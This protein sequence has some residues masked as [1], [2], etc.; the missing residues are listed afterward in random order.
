MQFVSVKTTV[1]HSVFF[2]PFSIFVF[3]SK[4]M[5]FIKIREEFFIF[6]PAGGIVKDPTR[7][8]FLSLF[9]KKHSLKTLNKKLFI[10]SLRGNMKA[11]ALFCIFLLVL[12]LLLFG[13][14]SGET[15]EYFRCIHTQLANDFNYEE[16]RYIC[17]DFK[18]TTTTTT[19]TTTKT[20]TSNNTSAS[21]NT[22]AV[23]SLSS[24]QQ[25]EAATLPRRARQIKTTPY[26]SSSAFG[27]ETTEP[28]VK[29]TGKSSSKFPVTRSPHPTEDQ[30][31]I[32]P[33]CL[34]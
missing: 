7:I 11:N 19:T 31:G 20:I 15:D 25:T 2:Y 1:S 18:T 12:L 32:R 34:R 6:C 14:T 28:V 17:F 22:V 23:V 33:H 13:F 21:N 30:T 8:F 10:F 29:S 24:R 3:Y 16:S 9:S 4:A 26:L 5:T 27:R